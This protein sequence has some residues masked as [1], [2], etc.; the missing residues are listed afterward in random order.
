MSIFIVLTNDIHILLLFRTSFGIGS[1]EFNIS[2]W[3]VQEM[4]SAKTILKV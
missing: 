4:N 1:Y 2:L 3:Y